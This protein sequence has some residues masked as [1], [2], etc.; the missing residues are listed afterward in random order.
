MCSSLAPESA[1]LFSRGSDQGGVGGEEMGSPKLWE[2]GER[3]VQKW[4]KGRMG[5]LGVLAVGDN[6]GKRSRLPSPAWDRAHTEI[7]ARPQGPQPLFPRVAETTTK[8][9][10]KKKQR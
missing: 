10:R 6:F 5:R 4:G 2:R 8:K 9:E 3:K 7:K 1:L